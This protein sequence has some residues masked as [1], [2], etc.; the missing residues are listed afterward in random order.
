MGR[1]KRHA[2]LCV[3]VCCNL[4]TTSLLSMS[5]IMSYQVSLS[6]CQVFLAVAH[7]SFSLRQSIIKNSV[8][9]RTDKFRFNYFSIKNPSFI[10]NV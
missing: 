10:Y 2:F 6:H 4:F 1:G 9:V 8:S 7:T 3:C 5:R